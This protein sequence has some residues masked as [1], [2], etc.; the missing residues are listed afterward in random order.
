MALD[1]D[2]DR[3]TNP[4]SALQT[5]PPSPPAFSSPSTS[6]IVYL[7]KHSMVRDVVYGRLPAAYR[8]IFHRHAARYCEAEAAEHVAAE[9]HA[10][11]LQRRRS[12]VARNSV[13]SSNN[14]NNS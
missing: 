9:R 12:L 8:C 1:G 7:F 14:N 13:I 2:N 11:L 10:L 4:S 3:R 6:S 5:S